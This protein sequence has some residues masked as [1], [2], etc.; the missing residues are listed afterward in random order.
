MSVSEFDG[1]EKAEMFDLK[2]PTSRFYHLIFLRFYSKH[3]MMLSVH[4]S[5]QMCID[6][7]TAAVNSVGLPKH[8]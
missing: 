8:M 3:V 4:I 2:G 1:R 5:L 6:Y 7:S